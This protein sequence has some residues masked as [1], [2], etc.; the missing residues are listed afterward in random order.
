MSFVWLL[1][2]LASVTVLLF[3]DPSAAL[4]AMITGANDSVTLALNLVALYGIWLGVFEILEST[5]VSDKLARVLRPVV[6]LL[7]KGESEETEKYISMNISANLLGLGNAATPMGIGAVGSM[8]PY[9]KDARKA[10]P[11]MIMLIVISATSLQLFP[12]TVIGLRAAAGSADPA[13]FLLPC[14][15]ATVSSTVIGVAGVKLM[16]VLTGKFGRRKRRQLVI[17]EKSA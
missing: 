16:T 9:E 6:R 12:S 14:T 1:I 8:K 4:E 10:S 13:D 5:G 11:N 2:M 17:R 3:T 7:F 15:A